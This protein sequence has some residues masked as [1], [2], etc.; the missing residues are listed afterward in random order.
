MSES[1]SW[2]IEADVRSINA[3]ETIEELVAQ[4]TYAQAFLG[5]VFGGKES[6]S[7]AKSDAQRNWE[8]SGA[9]AVLLASTVDEGLDLPLQVA[10]DV[11]GADTLRTIEL[12]GGQAEEIGVQFVN[13][14][15]S[16]S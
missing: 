15:W 13:I 10:P 6:D 5:Y 8:G 16:G 4:H 3:S 14:E 9:K 12:T 2:A 1:A 7:L 11:Q